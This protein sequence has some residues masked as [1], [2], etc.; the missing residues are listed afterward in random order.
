MRADVSST[1]NELTANGRASAVSRGPARRFAVPSPLAVI[2]L[3]GLA[4]RLALLARDV[5]TLDSDEATL[6]LM[7]IHLLHG[8]WFAYFWGQQYMGSLEAILAAPLIAVL[9]PTTLA[10]RLPV[11]LM[12]L[13]AVATV[14]ALGERL[15]SRR[16]GL[17]CATLLAIGPAFFDTLSSRTRGGYVET[18]LIGNLLLLL[19]LGANPARLLTRRRCALLG[20]L[21]GVGLWTN[22][23][24]APYLLATAALLWLQRRREVFSRTGL[25]LLAGVALGGL[26]AIVYN[27]THG[28]PTLTNVLGLTVAGSGSRHSMIPLGLMRHIVTELTTSL[29]ILAGGFL[30]GSQADGF[31]LGDYQAAMRAHP[32]L[33][34]LTMAIVLAAVALFA[35]AL[36]QTARAVRRLLAMRPDGQVGVGDTE[37]RQRQYGRAALLLVVVLYAAAFCLSS[38][39]D[40]VATPRYLFPLYAGAPLVVGQAETLLRQ[41]GARW[42]ALSGRR[43]RTALLAV[44][45]A[46][47][48]TWNLAGA[49]SLTPTQ[50]AARDH[51]VWI[52]GD[53]QPLLALLRAHH[54]RT[55]ISN[56]YWEGLRLSYESGETIIPVMVTPEG[57]PGF[58]RYRPYVREG[59]ADARPAYV[60][61]RGTPEAVQHHQAA[62]SG[63]LPGYRE[64]TVGL[65]TVLVPA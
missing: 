33:Y 63:A 5:P 47:L 48:V 59:L 7:G 46:A 2:V 53:D 60:E 43:A 65:Y 55:V 8:Q 40:I 34:A 39:S 20:I 29:P 24:I 62:L 64:T 25:A 36:T 26:P 16:V 58:N 38:Q 9:G 15:F 41:A 57:H 49:I 1:P 30:G 28:A 3:A 11:I 14:Y 22:V 13:G 45:L 52:T 12:G 50:T 17:V 54:V 44:P 6:G 51:G 21:A 42:T 32:F 35:L 37:E 19:V 18:L 61:L 27:A 31:T 4:L 23:L 56:D 10:L